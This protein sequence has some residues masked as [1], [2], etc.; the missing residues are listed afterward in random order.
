MVADPLRTPRGFSTRLSCVGPGTQLATHSTHVVS[1][2]PRVSNRSTSRTAPRFI[3]RRP[4]TAKRR[5]ASDAR[6]YIVNGT[7]KWITGG[8]QGT[9]WFF[10]FP[11][12]KVVGERRE[13]RN[14]K[15]QSACDMRIKPQ[16]MY[17]QRCSTMPP[18]PFLDNQKT[19]LPASWS[20]P[21]KRPLA[22]RPPAVRP[23]GTRTGL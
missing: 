4:S 18:T 10:S 7:K 9:Q 8:M 16:R 20:P 13:G 23:R 15:L 11:P 21:H 5:D 1:T 3:D 17:T 19:I 12:T 6:N 22:V 14:D 2:K